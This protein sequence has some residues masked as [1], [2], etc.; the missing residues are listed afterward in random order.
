MYTDTRRREKAKA[1]T[2]TRQVHTLLLEDGEPNKL[3][4]VM[5]VFFYHT[6]QDSVITSATEVITLAV[7]R[8]SYKQILTRFSTFSFATLYD[9]CLYR[10]FS[11]H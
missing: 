7:S 9:Y 2:G 11:P 5:H 10:G 6:S 3:F 8:G 1:G 4:I